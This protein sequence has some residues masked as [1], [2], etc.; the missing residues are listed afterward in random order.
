M[1]DGSTVFVRRS[2]AAIAD[3][4]VEQGYAVC[5]TTTARLLRA[6]GYSPKVNVQRF[7]GP[8][9]PQ[10]DEQFAYLSKQQASFWLMGDPIISVDAK[11]KELIGNF[12]NAGPRWCT[13]ADEVLCHDFP[14]QALC[15]A[16]PYGI[17]DV[18]LNR[19][20]VCVA[21]SA[22]TSAFAV[23]AI[24]GWW[25]RAGHRQYPHARDLLILADSGGS[26]GCRRRLWKHA[27]QVELADRYGLSI[28]V[29]HYPRG[30]SKWNPIEH[31]LFG[32]IS[33][34]WAGV[35]LRSLDVLLS[36][37][38]GT[39]TTTGLRVRAW[40]NPHTYSHGVKVSDQQMQRLRLNYH[41]ICPQWNYTIE[42]RPTW[43]R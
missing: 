18:R 32:P 17:Y 23:D 24:R 28:T 25:T 7:C 20:H 30:A 2:L 4:L 43:A 11:K 21:T 31:R 37:L 35:P 27:L 19:G 38:R 26:N 3:D 41:S 39:R 36:C 6:L 34:N 12:A 33:G 10:R 29:C 40:L 14:D 1:P 15:R 5:P 13:D 16:T 22:D 9:H 42:P 8:P